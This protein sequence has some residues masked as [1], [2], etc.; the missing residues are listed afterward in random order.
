[1]WNIIGCCTACQHKRSPASDNFLKP[2]CVLGICQVQCTFNMFLPFLKT[3]V[4]HGFVEN[5][6]EETIQTS[7]ELMLFI[8]RIHL[9]RS[10]SSTNMN[11]ASSRSHVLLQL[12]V[13][14]QLLTGETKESRLTFVDLAGSERQSKTEAKGMRFTEA[15]NINLS[16]SALGNVINSLTSNTK[17]KH[18]PY[19][20][21]KLTRILQDSLGGNSNKT[22]YP[23]FPHFYNFRFVFSR[24]F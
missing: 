22:F 10:I 21:S 14:Q 19:R 15:I 9:N 24:K 4:D 5:L 17:S 23:R 20:D 16:L 18:I 8:K 2:L 11:Q 13:I 7:E 12:R 6:T 3:F 1:M